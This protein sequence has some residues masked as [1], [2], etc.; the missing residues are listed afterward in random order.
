MTPKITEAD[1]QRIEQQAKIEGDILRALKGKFDADSFEYGYKCGSASELTR[2]LEREEKI[3]TAIEDF[4]CARTT[5]K[6][7][8]PERRSD[9]MQI[10]DNIICR[11]EACFKAKDAKGEE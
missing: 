8:D 7:T 1:K 4:K 5:H 6:N 10:Y 11:L 9:G 2:C 3:K